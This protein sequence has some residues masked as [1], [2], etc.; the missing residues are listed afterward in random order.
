MKTIAFFFFSFMV[1]MQEALTGFS[2]CGL[3]LG[4]CT[5]DSLISHEGQESITER[6]F[7]AGKQVDQ[8]IIS[9][10]EY[11]SPGFFFFFFCFLFVFC[12]QLRKRKQMIFRIA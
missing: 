3:F 7:G 4:F 10:A 8:Q 5:C 6:M 12:Y 1:I 9:K 11:G 2:Q